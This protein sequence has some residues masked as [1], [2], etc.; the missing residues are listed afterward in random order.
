LILGLDSLLL[1]SFS[2]SIP[3]K[4]IYNIF[5]VRGNSTIDNL[6]LKNIEVLDADIISST[7]EEIYGVD[8]LL[9]A[10]FENTLRAGNYLAL[11]K[12]IDKW[13]IKRKKVGEFSVKTLGSVDSTT[14]EYTDYSQGNKQ[15]YEYQVYPVDIDGTEGLA[16]TTIT[17]SDF[18]GWFLSDLNNTVVYKFDMEVNSDSIA[19][20][21]DKKMY[22]NFTKYPVFRTGKRKYHSGGLETIPYELNGVDINISLELLKLLE[23]FINNEDTK[24][25]RNSKGEI[26]YVQTSDFNYKYMDNIA[27][28]P[29]TISFK[30]TEVAEV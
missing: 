3:D 20:N 8:T 30:F 26:F 21:I 2:S 17:S 23:D 25:L 28:Q 11:S 4:K 16:I 22:E 19:I 18:Y 9:L 7:T 13:V 14:F 27:E 10:N 1:N 29:Y 5:E 12:P 6:H 24:V 15:Q